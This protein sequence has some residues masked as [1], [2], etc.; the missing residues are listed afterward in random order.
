MFMIETREF[1]DSI[2]KSC[3][4]LKKFFNSSR[5]FQEILS[6]KNE[7]YS[8][9]PLP[10]EANLS[11]K[12]LVC[13]IAT[14]PFRWLLAVYLNGIATLFDCCG[15][16]RAKTMKNWC[17]TL[18]IGFDVFSEE[19]TKLF[20]I[21][22]SENH[23][24]RE[25]KIVNNSPSI[26]ESRVA[27]S[28]I[29][30]I[31]FADAQLKKIEFNYHSGICYGMS[32]WFLYL[33]LKTKNQF[34][35]LR[36]HMAAIGEQFKNGG[37]MDSTILQTFYLGER[38]LLNL[39]IGVQPEPIQSFR[40]TP[41]IRQTS[42]QWTTN[43]AEMI[44]QL[45]KMPTGNYA[46]RVTKHQTAFIKINDELGY[47]FDPNC[48]IIELQGKEIAEKLY[49][50][51]STIWKEFGDGSGKDHYPYFELTPVSLRA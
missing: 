29:K 30:R 43:S 17:V 3:A 21:A 10:L 39:K 31:W 48:G 40:P 42:N 4:N 38:N 14:A 47:F 12:W 7:P 24:N 25:G 32:F 27:A 13:Q 11:G 26:P 35:D 33:Y 2:F 15:S 51:L 9:I 20:K 49:E 50:Q 34:Q 5:A 44:S 23:P 16:S 6:K 41:L 22:T 8:D 19:K 18:H 1:N 46:V 45:R 37:G 28:L 36:S